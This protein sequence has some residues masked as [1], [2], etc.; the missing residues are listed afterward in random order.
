[1]VRVLIQLKTSCL[2]IWC[3]YL[4]FFVNGMQVA[5]FYQEGEWK[6]WVGDSL[7]CCNI[8]F[9]F[10]FESIVCLSE[11]WRMKC[12][13]K[14]DVHEHRD[15]DD[16]LVFEHVCVI[17]L[18]GW[19]CCC[20]HAC[21]IDL[22]KVDLVSKME[23]MM[24]CF[25]FWKES[26]RSFLHAWLEAS[27]VLKACFVGLVSSP[28]FV[29]R[30][31][32][33]RCSQDVKICFFCWSRSLCH[34]VVVCIFVN[35]CCWQLVKQV[36]KKILWSRCSFT[37][38]WATLDQWSRQRRS[39]YLLWSSQQE[40]CMK[41]RRK[42]ILPKRTNTSKKE[43]GQRRWF[44]GTMQCKC[45]EAEIRGCCYSHLLFRSVYQYFGDQKLFSGKAW[46]KMDLG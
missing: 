46:S 14:L 34:P 4:H 24:K 45:M 21:N 23:I 31:K 19:L 5:K 7:Y 18:K 30:C 20:K 37:F 41:S 13:H 15:V 6:S 33:W 44:R 42:T 39:N 10:S 17:N 28:S 22:R 9:H 27:F 38:V 12:M 2:L 40:F 11:S 16:F 32:T 29:C 43:S 8:I 25:M 26:L 36:Q 35:S 1:M 3:I